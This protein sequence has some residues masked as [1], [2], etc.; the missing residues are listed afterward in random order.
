MV[1]PRAYRKY[2]TGAQYNKIL[3]PKQARDEKMM[4]QRRYSCAK[5]QHRVVNYKYDKFNIG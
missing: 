1:G 2:Q 3:P 4:K 5:H